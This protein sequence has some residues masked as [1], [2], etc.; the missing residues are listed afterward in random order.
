MREVTVATVQM[1]PQLGQM[2]D[3]LVA[4]SN[5]IKQVAT[6]QRVDLIIFPE[7][8]TTGR[9]CGVSFTDFAQRVPGPS[10]NLVA[11][12][13]SEYG[14]HIAFGLVTKEKVE[15]ILYNT[16]VLVGPE[17]DP[18]PALEGIDRVKR[19]PGVPYEQLPHLAR[20]ADVLIMPYADLP[21]TRAMQPLKMTEYLATGKP[22]VVRDLPA[23]RPWS[24]A[25]DL[26]ATPEEFAQA[27]RRRLEEG[28]CPG[29]IEARRRLEREGW[30]EKAR[31]FERMAL[32]L[33]P[34]QEPVAGTADEA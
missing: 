9:E 33:D 8:I 5:W 19:L 23:A 28:I 15:S 16:V 21:V 31:Q 32:Q 18:D 2:E 11:Q 25:M 4:M 24:D 30:A 3:N 13:A 14:V 17:A 27:V 7:L 34:K 1:K 26:A 22:A 10:V 12:R 6:E 29:Q 20:E